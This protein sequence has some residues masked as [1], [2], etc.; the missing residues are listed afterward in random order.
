MI[1]ILALLPVGA[2]AQLAQAQNATPTPAAPKAVANDTVLMRGPGGVI[3]AA[4]FHAA[5]QHLVPPAQRES[6]FAKPQNIEQLALLIYTRQ[7]LAQQAK[8][9]G[10]D[11]EAGVASILDIA[12]EQA[13]S[14]LWLLKQTEA[15]EPTPQQL[16][17][18]AR[19]VYNAQPAHVRES[20][21]LKVRHILVATSPTI[22]D[23][24]AKAK[25]DR[26][27][28]ELKAGA[29]F[30]ELARTESSDKSSAVKGGELPLVAIGTQLTQFDA[31]AGKLTKPGE[32]SGVVRTEYGYHIIQLIERQ[33][34]SGFER[35]RAD[36]IEQARARLAAQSRAELLKTAQSG[37]EP[38]TSAISALVREPAAK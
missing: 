24:Q 28:G 36:L 23:A 10:F 14:D 20:V 34:L 4:Q 19:S 21:Q 9:Q 27:L 37:A 26:L 38:D 29:K 22:D 5:V 8:Q 35:Q 31:A 17:Q 25:A 2:Q 30:E 15:R 3:T 13:L 12:Q 33:T 32:I 1:G 6:F 11:R 7:T 16:E 18:Y